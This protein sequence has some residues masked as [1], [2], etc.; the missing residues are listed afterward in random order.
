MDKKLDRDRA[1][2][3]KSLDQAV[4]G[5][6]P[7]WEGINIYWRKK[8]EPDWGCVIGSSHQVIN[9]T[10]VDKVVENYISTTRRSKFT[11]ASGASLSPLDWGCLTSKDFS[12]IVA[13][14]MSNK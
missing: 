4:K 5:K 10:Y 8:W 9:I 3:I 6:T 11:R 7:S 12:G 1:V 13:E 14:D 2:R